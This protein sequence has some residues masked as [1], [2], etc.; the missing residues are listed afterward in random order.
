MHTRRGRP[1]VRREPLCATAAACS[2]NRATAPQPTPLELVLRATTWPLHARRRGAPRGEWA[3][4]EMGGEVALGSGGLCFESPHL[5]RHS[6]TA[7]SASLQ[8]VE[9][10]SFSMARLRARLPWPSTVLSPSFP[11]PPL[12]ETAGIL[13][14]ESEPVL[15][16]GRRNTHRSCDLLTCG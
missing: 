5:P 10:R 2:D 4:V 14:L 1:A 16:S 11:P 9:R 12:V 3:R 6:L 13:V 15:G 8:V 7:A